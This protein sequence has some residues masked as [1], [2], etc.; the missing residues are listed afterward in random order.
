VTSSAGCTQSASFTI[1]QPGSALSLVA[2]KTD[3]NSCGGTGRITATAS[4]GTAPYQF[5]L[6]NGTPQST[7]SF[8][9]LATGTYTVRVT[10]DRGCMATT[11]LTVAD[12]GTDAYELNNRQTAA[13][14]IALNTVIQAR[15]APTATDLD[16]YSFTTTSTLGQ[17]YTLSLS[18]PT[19]SYLFDLYDSRGRVIAPSSSTATSKVYSGLALNT[20]YAIQVRGSQS[21]LTCYALGISNGAAV[22]R[23][24]A[25]EEPAMKDIG[26]PAS[27]LKAL[28]YPNPH[29][30]NVTIQ[31]QSSEDGPALLELF[32]SNG[33]KVLSRT[34]PLQKGSTTIPLYGLRQGLLLYRITT[35]QGQV[36]GKLVGGN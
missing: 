22:T 15:I 20:S 12:N 21:S 30:G 8:S 28:A 13:K 9:N 16:W 35:G 33:Q 5:T 26:T 1:T 27:E 23:I 31:V 6:N 14:V 25:P 2:S 3:I 29:Q 4:G 19:V 10:D 36:T 24:A 18:H 32:G 17:V 7:G 34:Y 11:T